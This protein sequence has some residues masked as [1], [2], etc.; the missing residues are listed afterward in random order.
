MTAPEECELS[1]TGGTHNPLAPTFEFLQRAFMPLI[2]RMGPQVELT[3]IRPGFFPA[4]GG[5]LHA[6]I[7]PARTLKGFSLLERGNILSTHATAK[8]SSLNENIAQRELNVVKQQLQWPDENLEIEN[9]ST[10]TGPG[11]VISLE[12]ASEHVTEVFA[13]IGER[14]VSAE[15]VAQHACNEAGKYL[16]RGAPVGP[17]L[18]DQLLLPLALS[19]EG[20]SFVTYSPTLHTRTQARII[21]LFMKIRISMTKMSNQ[22][23]LISVSP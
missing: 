20:G 1:I 10:A 8:L 13:S 21:E 12:I 7:R 17:H 23:C 6:H 16:K 14:G 22:L 9:I 2:H 19:S 18:A 3:L 4:G 15:T 11:N 5:R